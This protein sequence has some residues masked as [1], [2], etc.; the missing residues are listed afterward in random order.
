MWIAEKI[1]TAVALWALGY[2]YLEQGDLT[3]AIPVLEQAV[4]QANRYRSRQVQSWVRT[5]LGEA[6]RLIGQRDR[7]T[8]PG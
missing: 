8:L 3:D 7:S 5:F 4:E 2:A 1:E 6:Y